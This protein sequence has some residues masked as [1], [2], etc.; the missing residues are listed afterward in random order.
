MCL[1][2][3]YKQSDDSVIFRNVSRI[4]VDG[5]NIILRDIMGDERVV[6]GSI[7]MVDLANSVVKLTCE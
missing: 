6:K 1:A 3:V 2:T 5:E 4:D 7:L